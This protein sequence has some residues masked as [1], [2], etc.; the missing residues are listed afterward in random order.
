MDQPCTW[1]NYVYK[2]DGE[3]WG[4]A[5]TWSVPLDQATGRPRFVPDTRNVMYAGNMMRDIGNRDRLIV[6]FLQ[7]KAEIVKALEK[8]VG[9]RAHTPSPREGLTLAQG[10]NESMLVMATNEGHSTMVINFFCDLHRRNQKTPRHLVFATTERLRDRLRKLG[11]TAFWHE[12]LGTFEKKAASVYGT[13]G[14]GR[15]TYMKQFA[16]YLTL[17]L[18]WDVLFQDADVVWPTDPY[19]DL[20]RHRDEYHAQFMDD[21]ARTFRFAPFFANSG[22]YYLTNR[23]PG[24]GHIIEFVD[25]VTMSM[26]ES[27]TGNQEVLNAILEFQFKR[28]GF[29]LRILPSEKY[30]SGKYISPLPKGAA[31]TSLPDGFLVAHFCWTHNMEVKRERMHEYKSKHLRDDCFNDVFK[32]KVESLKDAASFITSSAK[33]CAA[34]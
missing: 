24:A 17:L 34:L 4:A 19:P 9:K 27:Q 11:I 23:H 6:P 21:G 18:G 14:F 3:Y 5:S 26:A 22:F 29:K 15:L 31:P 28:R 1:H 25:Q 33:M 12:K 32:C 10:R 30:A 20:I 8:V 13:I 16:T 7:H 2:Y